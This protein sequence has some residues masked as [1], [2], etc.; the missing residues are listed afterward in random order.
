MGY[1]LDVEKANHDFDQEVIFWKE[2]W[3]IDRNRPVQSN[4][5]SYERFLLLEIKGYWYFYGRSSDGSIIKGLANEV[6]PDIFN[7]LEKKFRDF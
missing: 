7:E 2:K 4:C 6:I 5:N 3:K 1:F